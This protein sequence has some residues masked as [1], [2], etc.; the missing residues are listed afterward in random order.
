MPARVLASCFGGTIVQWIQK[1]FLSTVPVLLH[2]LSH[3]RYSSQGRW[4]EGAKQRTCSLITT[5]DPKGLQLP[6]PSLSSLHPLQTE[7]PPALQQGSS[8]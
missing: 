4:M 7:A 3:R 8:L 5:K 2:L 6:C 1:T